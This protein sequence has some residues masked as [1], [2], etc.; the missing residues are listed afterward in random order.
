ML[1]KSLRVKNFRVHTDTYLEFS[2]N[3][4]FLS[5]GNGQGKTTLIEAIYFLCTSKNFKSA[6]DLELLQFGR[7][8]YEIT[9]LFRGLTDN[10]NSIFFS[11]L[12]NK[13]AY[14]QDSKPVSRASDIVGRFP[15][16]LLTPHDS[17]LTH[18][19]PADRRKFID[20]ILSQA[21]ELYLNTLLDYNKTLKHR[22]SLL[23][24]LSENRR[25][26]YFEELEA[27]NSKLV[28]EGT[29]LIEYRKK[30]VEQFKYHLISA[31]SEIMLDEETPEI[32]YQNFA[33]GNDAVEDVFSS[34]LSDRME[35]EILRRS[36][37]IGPHR[38]EFIFK[39]NDKNLKTFGSQGQHKTFQVALKFAQ[40]FYLKER[41]SKTAIFLL[42]DVFGELD[43]SRAERI[44]H[45]LRRVGQVFIT[46]TDFSNLSFLR[47]DP[48]DLLININGGNAAY[49]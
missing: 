32:E 13:R 9:G 45:Y 19:Y 14:V 5:G 34:L 47:T 12:E 23:N 18:G 2:D 11:L 10:Y 22:A 43:K 15:V 33:S 17:S 8:D 36:N 26:D 49:A 37:L 27:W 46:I 6:S 3:L 44:S 41:F 31:Y 24:K 7:E 20:S 29:S 42:D 40:F 35:E 16:V 25:G 4:N 39:V 28:Q 38:D 48:T 21:S 30:F 1:L